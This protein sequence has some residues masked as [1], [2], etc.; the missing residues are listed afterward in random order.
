[1]ED[2]QG[3]ALVMGFLVFKACVE[4]NK[5]LILFAMYKQ[6][7]LT[8]VNYFTKAISLTVC[9]LVMICFDYT[10]ISLHIK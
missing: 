1:M 8:A 4:C 6:F 2:Y 10:G 7:T 3:T 5:F 9:N